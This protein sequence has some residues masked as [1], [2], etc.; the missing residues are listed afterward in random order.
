M[1]CHIA[2]QPTM[3]LPTLAVMGVILLAARPSQA[4]FSYTI[5]NNSA[6]ITGYA[7]PGGAVVVPATLGGAPVQAL[8]PQAF[9]QASQVTSISLP[10]SVTNIASGAFAYCFSLDSINVNVTNTYYTSV[11]GILYDATQE[12]L[13]Q[14]PGGLTG[15]FTIPDGVTTIGSEAFFSDQLAAVTIPASVTTIANAAFVSCLQLQNFTVD[16]G[17]LF[18]SAVG[19]VLFNFDRTSLIQYPAELPGSSYAIPSTVL[20]IG[21]YAFGSAYNLTSLF[22]PASVNSLGTLPFFEC[23][24]LLTINVDPANLDY[25]SRNGVLFNR[26]QSSLISFPPGLKGSYVVPNGITSIGF[27]A[28]AY[29]T[30]SS[31]TLPASLTTIQDYGF[32]YNQQLTTATF[33][34]NPPVFDATAFVGDNLEFLYLPGATGWT[35]PLEGIPALLWNPVIQSNASSPAIVNNNFGFTIT[36][37]S[38]INVSVQSTTNLAGGTWLPAQQVTLV[39][40]SSYFSVPANTNIPASFFRLSTP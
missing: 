11:G 14:Y 12:T 21:N 18:F 35:S 15:D 31:V 20:N 22:I 39:N 28:F 1:E 25:S 6:T 17:N 29:S 8:G 40:G 7:G 37:T 38:N 24:S 34:G 23:V 16:P 5:T 30:L 2:T 32:A 19:G 3:K 9:F 10:A 33:L 26:D 4:Q 27:Q 36:G 13:V